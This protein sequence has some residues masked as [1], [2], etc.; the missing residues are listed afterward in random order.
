MALLDHVRIKRINPNKVL[1][2]V[3]GINSQRRIAA[4]LDVPFALSNIFSTLHLAL[5]QKRL[6]SVESSSLSCHLASGWFGQW[7]A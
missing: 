6:T 3:P 7:E 4:V 2:A 1:R 5:C